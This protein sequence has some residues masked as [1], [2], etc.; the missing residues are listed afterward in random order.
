MAA[1]TI[2]LSVRITPEDAEFIAGLDVQGATTPSEKV[3][4]VLAEARRRDQ[5]FRDY[6]G[7]L[8][9]AQDMLSAALRRL[10]EAERE[11][12]VHSE[13]VSRVGEWLPEVMAFLITSHAA[14]TAAEGVAELRRVESALADRVFRL[15]EG[16]MRMGVTDT[17]QGYDPKVVAS[18][19]NPI[20]ELA[21]VAKSHRYQSR[22]GSSSAEPDADDDD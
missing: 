20:L 22:M 7:C 14:E 9:M 5:E 17:C 15:L 16:T 2:P 4:A 3:R 8:S 12:D 19:L 10:R 11:H 6:Q 1:R 18:R 13:L 21:G